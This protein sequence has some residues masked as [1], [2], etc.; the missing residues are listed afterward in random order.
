MC[1]YV[2]A[3]LS[4]RSRPA[5]SRTCVRTI[6]GDLR[7]SLGEINANKCGGRAEFLFDSEWVATHV[8]THILT[9]VGVDND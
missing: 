8:H 6:D 4:S 5:D 9:H 1:V 3:A 2:C 7:R